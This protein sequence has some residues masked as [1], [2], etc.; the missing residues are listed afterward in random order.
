MPICTVDFAI[1]KQHEDALTA[2]KACSRM[3]HEQASAA[4]FALTQTG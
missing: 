1:G 2:Q 3:H 4:T